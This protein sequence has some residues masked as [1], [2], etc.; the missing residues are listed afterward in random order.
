MTIYATSSIL[1][2]SDI[3][4]CSTSRTPTPLQMTMNGV[5]TYPRMTSH[6]TTILCNNV[7]FASQ[8]EQLFYRLLS[9]SE[10]KQM[11]FHAVFLMM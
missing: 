4:V 7:S 2:L 8:S 11:K 10:V 5:L 1:P 9:V 6:T 3:P